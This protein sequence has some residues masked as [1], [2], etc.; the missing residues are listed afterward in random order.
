MS[1]LVNEWQPGHW[2]LSSTDF[3]SWKQSPSTYMH[4]N[5][6]HM[7][8]GASGLLFAY[9]A[10]CMLEKYSL[11]CCECDASIGG[12]IW[13]NSYSSCACGIPAR[14]KPYTLEPN[15]RLVWLQCPLARD[16]GLVWASIEVRTRTDCEAEH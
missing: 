3:D 4:M 14:T 8:A 1:G 5:L 16:L 2:G 7:G 15:T 6:I 12:T 11:V 9:L 10:H 13:Q